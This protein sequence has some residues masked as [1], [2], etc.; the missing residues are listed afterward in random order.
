MGLNCKARCFQRDGR[1]QC[2]SVPLVLLVSP[3]G[4]QLPLRIREAP[5]RCLLIR[6]CK[7][8]HVLLFFYILNVYIV[9]CGG[10]IQS[11][12]VMKK[13][14]NQKI[15]KECHLGVNKNIYIFTVYMI[16]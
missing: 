16:I 3:R 10:W 6:Y 9:I 8:H 13:S 14:R 15:K 12:T 7:S 4:G 5:T 2:C 1:F 11:F